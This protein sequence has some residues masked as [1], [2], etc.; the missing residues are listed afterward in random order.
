[1]PEPLGAA[2][3]EVMPLSVAPDKVPDRLTLFHGVTAPPLPEDAVAFVAISEPL[4]APLAK[5]TLT[6]A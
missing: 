6:L 4:S 5:L 3:A 1:M 2:P